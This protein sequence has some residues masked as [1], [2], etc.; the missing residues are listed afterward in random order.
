MNAERRKRLEAIK[1]QLE[2]IVGDLEG[3]RDEEQEAFDN[4]PEGLQGSEKGDTMQENIS[5]I[6]E[7]ISAAEEAKEVELGTEEKGQPILILR[8]ESAK[9]LM[10]FADDHFPANTKVWEADSL[11][12]E[13]VAKGPSYI[14][15]NKPNERAKELIVDTDED[16]AAD[17]TEHAQEAA[18]NLDNVQ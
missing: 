17:M 12:L 10:T 15:G 4:M 6:E 1:S 9:T 3:I 5:A 11:D 13:R 18:D 14:A 7:A 16:P 2:S 8:F